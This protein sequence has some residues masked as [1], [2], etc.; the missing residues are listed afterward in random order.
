MHLQP[1]SD[2][3]PT[4]LRQR[5]RA[6]GVTVLTV[7]SDG[8]TQ[9]V[10]ECQWFENTLRQA[11]VLVAA[12]REAWPALLEVQGLPVEMWPGLWLVPLPNPR[13]R[14][15]NHDKR[16][17]AMP[18]ALLVTPEFLT[19]D[20]FHLL[21]GQCQLD[22]QLTL[23]RVNH[24]R[25]FSAAEVQRLAATITWMQQDVSEIDRRYHELQT[26]GTQLGESYEELS[27]LYKLSTGM[28]LDRP[29]M[30]FLSEACEDLQQTVGLK[31][32]AIQLVEDQPALNELSG[33]VI[34]AGPVGC[35]NLMLKRIGAM[36]MLR[37]GPGSPPLIV[38]DTGTLQIQ[39]LPR[40]ARD[41]L[42]VSLV[43]E[44]KLLGILIGGDKLDGQHISSIDSKLCSSLAATL[45]MFL[46]NLM[47]YEDMSAM[48]MGT[49]HALTASIDAK[50]RY[51]FGHSERVALLSRQLAEAAGLDAHTTER[52]YLSGLVHDVGKIGVPEHVL[53]KPGQLTPD[54]FSLIKQ[55]PE[56]GARILQDI[57]QMQDLIPG[58]LYH[59]ER[60]DGQGYP[61]GLSGNDIPL[62]G[63]LICL[64]DSFDA[65]SST[66]TYRSSLTHKR[67]LEEVRRCGGSQ[68]DPQLTQVF[69]QLDL[70]P[71]VDMI[72]KHQT[73][74]RVHTR[75]RLARSA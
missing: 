65:M 5:L 55:H 59:H 4:R 34:T 37:Q 68:F 20:Q 9:P 23:S 21:C 69:L 46:D 33:Q 50:D 36:L 30:Q 22:Y 8:R 16:R 7:D 53:C 60:W 12:L 56:I 2:V 67:V 72:Q 70:Q 47:L 48:F 75:P 62:F 11:P 14:R 18:V 1:G 26:M 15:V 19:S 29:P 28:T 39:H 3:L 61:H 31:W 32:M 13:R 52:V 6:L 51:T 40:L 44:D 43:R 10:D 35:D 24:D 17:Q 63:R 58:V 25:L 45:S 64:A 74:Q 54:E 41:L 42:V 49:L 66:R 27:L 38:D 71:F 57:R 73:Q